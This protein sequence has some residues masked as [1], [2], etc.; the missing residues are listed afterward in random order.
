MWKYAFIKSPVIILY[1]ALI[2]AAPNASVQATTNMIKAI[3]EAGA[4]NFDEVLKILPVVILFF[5]I[6]GLLLYWTKLS[7]AHLIR[8]AR[9]KLKED[10]F[11]NVLN[12]NNDQ[13]FDNTSGEYIAM[14]SNDISLLEYK[15]FN[16]QLEM[17]QDISTLIT[18][19][20]ALF[21][22][23]PILGV[24]I[25]IWEL[26]S[27]FICLLTRKNTIRDN[28]IFISSLAHF[29]QRAKDFLAAFPTI[30]NYA[31]EISVTAEFDK[32]NNATEEKKVVADT[33]VNFSNILSRYFNSFLKFLLVAIGVAMMMMKGMTVGTLLAAYKFTDDIVGPIHGIIAKLNSVNAVGS[34]INRVKVLA[35][36]R[37]E[38]SQ[39]S[40]IKNEFSG[41]SFNHVSLNK[42]GNT[43]LND[44]EFDFKPNKKYLIIG[45]NGSGKSSLLRL[46]K[47][48]NDDYSGSI[49][50]GKQE[51]KSISLEAL[52][53]IISYT[54][55]HS[56][57][58]DDTVYNNI[59]LYRCVKTEQVYLAAKIAG[60]NIPFDRVIRDGGKN[61]SSGERRRIELARCLVNSPSVVVF[62]EAISTLDIR[63]AYE[64]EKTL[65]SMKNV[66][67][68]FVSHNFSS[69][70]VNHYDA[71]LLMDE[72]RITEYGT[73]KE[74]LA[75]SKTYRKLMQ[76]KCGDL[77]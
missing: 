6:H 57:L 13:Y 64:I 60:V 28:K 30:R 14:F 34:I 47:R 19:I 7:K 3:D 40:D 24:V 71:I 23:N 75:N 4:G 2:I 37:Q 20:S 42:N 68:I 11:S 50:I 33:T 70:L 17:L 62:D 52:T 77:C 53:K 58:L 48:S 35:N 65:L 25:T 5:L 29:T 69:A 22:L 41:I 51:L 12:I 61:L 66:T 45:K 43:I 74:L 54:N 18:Y 49:L 55:E 21:I 46:M 73:H 38:E 15:Y 8:V 26:L 44:V 63:S 31:A 76:I 10:L 1:V 36:K 32:I 59:A 56:I 9:K 39:K 67:I 27:L 16:S 72:G